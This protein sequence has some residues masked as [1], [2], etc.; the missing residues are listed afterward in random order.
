MAVRVVDASVLA[1]L[2]FREPRADGA[3]NLLA[4]SELCAPDLLP[5]ELASVALKKTRSYPARTRELAIALEAVFRLDITLLSV[6]AADTLD[7]ALE[8]NL[9]VYDAA[10]LYLA[11]SLK[12]PLLTFDERLARHAI[13]K[14]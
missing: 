8:T 4:H 6:A 10:Y 11:R 1:A 14:R 5:Y 12:C 9:T 7:L 13:M 2:A 3:A